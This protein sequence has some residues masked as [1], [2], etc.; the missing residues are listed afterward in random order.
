MIQFENS[1][2]TVIIKDDFVE[3]ILEAAQ[4]WKERINENIEEHII[5]EV[6]EQMEDGTKYISI[7]FT[8]DDTTAR[9]LGPYCTSALSFTISKE[10]ITLGN[11]EKKVRVKKGSVY[12]RLNDNSKFI[13]ALTGVYNSDSA[14]LY[15]FLPVS[16]T[17]NLVSKDGKEQK[18]LDI[19]VDIPFSD[20]EVI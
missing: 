19:R 12:E 6:V 8:V 3:E 7:R 20:I 11:K 9:K 10:D 16:Y 4:W 14:Y 13:E 18:S 1:E 5:K 17:A 15:Y 2:H